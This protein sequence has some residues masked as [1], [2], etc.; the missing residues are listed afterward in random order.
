MRSVFRVA[1]AL[2]ALFWIA[3]GA[4]HADAA[5]V[6]VQNA[7][8]ANTGCT[9][10]IPIAATGAGDL[11]V[12]FVAIKNSATATALTGVS[13]SKSDPF[14]LVPGTDTTSSGPKQETAIFYDANVT[15]GATSVTVTTNA[16][17]V[18]DEG[19]VD[20]FSGNA[21][22]AALDPSSGTGLADT[23]GNTTVSLTT[24]KNGDLL[25]AG[26]IDSSAITYT[27]GAGY[28]LAFQ[29]SSGAAPPLESFAAEYQAQTTAGAISASF[30]GPGAA[31]NVETVFAGFAAG[32]APAGR[33]HTLTTLG[34]G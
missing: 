14:A 27:A 18:A 4:S 9:L 20:E 7:A 24:T 11:V 33:V 32:A 28:T 1:P 34:G 5:W 31:D 8:N 2:F 21:T 13:D 16:N 6:H 10:S 3:F 30:G 17:C 22:S 25:Y 23:T 26:S 19:I 12:V 29:S 15:G